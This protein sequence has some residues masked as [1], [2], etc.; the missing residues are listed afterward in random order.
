MTIPA[1]S[2][3]TVTVKSEPMA[4]RHPSELRP[5]QTWYW[6]GGLGVFIQGFSA[7]AGALQPYLAPLRGRL[8]DRVLSQS[9]SIKR[10][11]FPARPDEQAL[12]QG[13]FSRGRRKNDDQSEL[14]ETLFITSLC[15][16]VGTMYADLELC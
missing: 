3:D 4:V 16:C 12:D 5:V 8:R 7:L 13:T 10:H 11:L 15:V 6:H 14:D 1:D 9:L 2:N